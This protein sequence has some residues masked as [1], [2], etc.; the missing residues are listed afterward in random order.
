MTQLGTLLVRSK[1][2]AASEQDAVSEKIT[3]RGALVPG[4]SF[5]LSSTRLG[6]QLPRAEDIATA[7]PI[8]RN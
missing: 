6:I 5:A 2:E 1:V 8:V 7:P 4:V 3:L